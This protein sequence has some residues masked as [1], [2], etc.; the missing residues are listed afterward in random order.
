MIWLT[1][2]NHKPF[3]L[4]SDLIEQVEAMPDTIVT[5]I[6]G[7]KLIVSESADEVVERVIA[8]RRAIGLSGMSGPAAVGKALVEQ[9]LEAECD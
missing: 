3:V 7:Q 4:N 9:S 6:T 2:L 5:L 8:F 1:R